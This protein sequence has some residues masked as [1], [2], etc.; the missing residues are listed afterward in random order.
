MKIQQP[1]SLNIERAENGYICTSNCEIDD[2]EVQIVKELHEGDP[3]ENETIKKLL[4]GVAHYFGH[5][6]DKFGNANLKITFDGE[7]HKYCK[8]ERKK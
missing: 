3:D 2:D 5:D 8:P 4:E 6:Y 7:G 1:W